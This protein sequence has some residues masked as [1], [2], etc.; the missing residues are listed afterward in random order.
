MSTVTPSAPPALDVL[1]GLSTAVGQA[2]AIEPIYEAA[3]EAIA[4]GLGVARASILLFDSDRVMR[5]KAWRGLSDAYRAAVE[6]HTPWTPET[7]DAA[8]ITVPDVTADPGLAPYL[9]IVHAERIAAMTFVPLMTD[10]VV[11]KFMLYYGERHESSEG[12]LRL[13]TVIATQV[14]FAVQRLQ[15]EQIVR[16]AGLEH[17]DRRLAE[18]SARQLDEYLRAMIERTPEC[19]KIVAA[20][21]SLLEMNPAGLQL[22]EAESLDSVVGV[23]VYDIIA[24]EH[25]AAYRA[26]NDRICSGERGTLVFDIVG[27]RGTRRT[28]ETHAVPFAA[29]DGSIRHLAVTR[30]ITERRR[31][32]AALVESEAL[33]RQLADT[34][35]QIIWITG[36]DGMPNYFNARWYEFTGLPPGS[37]E[38]D[39]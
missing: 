9:P 5:F 17:G 35:P 21:G 39:D 36:A 27:L 38:R 24:P 22:I 15:S 20:D 31:A 12:E 33:F 34:L 1:L 26:F 25:R 32:E 30:D 14:A 3:L 23:S 29:S 11:G 2:A 7:T 10:H 13:A 28:M 6:G 8:P 4:R 16:A 37:L 19:V 18:S